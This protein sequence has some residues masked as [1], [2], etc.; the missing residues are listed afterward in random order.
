MD[1]THEVR[2]ADLW[3][4][5]EEQLNNGKM[6]RFQPQGTSMLPM[7][8]PGV[9]TVLLKKAPDM[10]KKNDLPL[11]IR[12]DGSFVLHRIVGIKNGKYIM[13]GDNQWKLEYNILPEQILGVTQGFYRGEKYVS[14]DNFFYRTYCTIRT[15]M[16][17]LRILPSRVK[18]KI[19][20]YVKIQ[21]KC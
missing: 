20:K 4:A 19:K 21:K 5:M 14:S 15:G 13:C 7:L 6:V 16:L 18:N 1:N 11:Y 8:R 9:D 10:L 3:P 12:A 2:L 17:K